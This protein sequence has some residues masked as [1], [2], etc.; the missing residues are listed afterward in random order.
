MLDFFQK[1]KI[2]LEK[3]TEKMCHNPAV[4][5]GI[6]QRGFIKE[7]YYADLVLVD[8]NASWVVST[9]NILYQCG[10]SPLEGKTF[11]N[12][13]LKTFVNG[14]LVYDNGQFNES[15]MGMPLKTLQQ[16][17]LHKS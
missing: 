16:K 15:K 1:G 13:V 12:K 5:Y 8:L 14:Q 11:K 4:L 10:W 17:N 2:S 7:G 3:I 6:E 9:D